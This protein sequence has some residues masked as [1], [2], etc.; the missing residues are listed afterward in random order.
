MR[1]LGTAILALLLSST[2]AFA[3]PASEASIRQLLEVTQVRRLLD[4]IRQQT[5]ALM[6]DIARQAT[7][8]QAPNAKQQAAIA[9]MKQ[10]MI[11]VMQAELAWEKMEP[12]YLRLYQ[13]T[14]SEE[15][16]AS[17]LDFYNTPAGKA[18][19]VKMPAL[20]QKTMHEVQAMVSALTPKMRQ[21][22]REFV[23]EMKAASR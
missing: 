6:N 1:I 22:E 23:D 7:R 21:I 19:V 12:L 16:V 3:A 9:K 14:F 20:V 11:G 13:E 4:D 18:L 8:G 10:K 17:M 5:Y 15:E 2:T